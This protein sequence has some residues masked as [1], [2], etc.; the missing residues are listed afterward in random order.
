M[1]RFDRTKIIK[2]WKCR[3]GFTC[4][5]ETLEFWEKG[6]NYNIW[7]N[8]SGIHLTSI[9]NLILSGEMVEVPITELDKRKM[10]SPSIIRTEENAG[11][12]D[13]CVNYLVELLEEDEFVYPKDTTPF[14]VFAAAIN[15]VYADNSVDAWNFIDR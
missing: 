8:L 4:L 6:F 10:P 5:D 14:F 9:K 2:A 12:Y 1:S 3:D 11:I 15:Y 13:S 7:N